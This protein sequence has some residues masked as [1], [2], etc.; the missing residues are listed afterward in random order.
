ML[1][2]Q[3]ITSRTTA[4]PRPLCASRLTRF[5]SPAWSAADV[6]RP[7]H[8]VAKVTGTV[9]Q[10]KADVLFCAGKA[11]VVS[12]G[13]ADRVFKTVK[14][15]LQYEREGDLFIALLTLSEAF[16]GPGVARQRWYPRHRANL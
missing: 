9:E 16:T 15:M 12:A 1:A 7:L 10:P 13:P 2:L 4:R 3:G 14:P 5:P 11:V 8:A 6:H